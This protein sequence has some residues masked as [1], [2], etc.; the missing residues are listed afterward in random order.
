MTLP[1]GKPLTRQVDLN[2][3]ELFNTVYLTR[4]LTEA[5]QRLGLS[6]SAVSHNLGRLRRAYGDELFVRLPRGVQPTP[7]ADGLAEPLR[8]ALDIVRDTLGRAPFMPERSERL[9]HLAMSD[10]G[11]RLCL[12]RL[13]EH[14]ATVAPGVV[15]RTSSP[16][17]ALLADG[18]AGG[19]IDLAVGYMPG[20]GKRFRQQR[21]FSERFVYVADANHPHMAEPPTLARMRSLRHVVACPPGTHHA[22]AVEE[23]LTSERV[24]APIAL[25]VGSFLSVAPI[26]AGSELVALLPSNLARV[27]GPRLGLRTQEPRVAFPG[28][29]VSM[30]WH[31]RY[32]REPGHAW[33]RGLLHDQFFERA[34]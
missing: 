21:L 17:L 5:G 24:R 19:A 23:V 10:I 25:R 34:L 8:V 2:L 6:Q 32:H 33:L 27:V 11:E 12:P 26:L 18:L 15:I 1:P 20:L 4:N 3:L 13:L 30:Y 28:F 7:F 9:F 16:D 29:E 31:P 22:A 14:L